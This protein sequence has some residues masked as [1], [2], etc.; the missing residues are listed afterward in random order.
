M[1][2]KWYLNSDLILNFGEIDSIG[3]ST[4]TQELT[5]EVSSYVNEGSLESARITSMW[6]LIYE[7]C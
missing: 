5:V 7:E 1:F 6:Y 3:S 2:L 4:N